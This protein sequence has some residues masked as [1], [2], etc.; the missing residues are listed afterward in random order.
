[1]Q[2]S[3]TKKSNQCDQTTYVQMTIYK[4]RFAIFSKLAINSQLSLIN[5]IQNPNIFHIIIHKNVR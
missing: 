3:P 5:K 2:Q 4:R 1:M